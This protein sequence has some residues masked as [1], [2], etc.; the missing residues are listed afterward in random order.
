MLTYVFEKKDR[1]TVSLALSSQASH[2]I[3]V[4]TLF[5]SF[6]TGHKNDYEMP[7]CLLDFNVKHS[8]ESKDS[9]H[10]LFFLK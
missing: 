7:V 10:R 2:S 1:K 8:I 5:I 6:Q 4:L 9:K 3:N